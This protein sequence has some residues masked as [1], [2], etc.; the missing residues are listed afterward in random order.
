[1]MEIVNVNKGNGAGGKIQIIMV[2]FL[3]QKQ[4][5]MTD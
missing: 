2:K 3:K 4:I 5:I 1:M